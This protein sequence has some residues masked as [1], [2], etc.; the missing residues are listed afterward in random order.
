MFQTHG[1]HKVLFDDN[2]LT[3]HAKGPFNSEQISIYQNKIESELQGRSAPWAQLNILYEDCLYPPEGEKTLHASLKTRKDIGICAIA[4][5]FV[6][7]SYTFI[8]E[9]QLGRMYALHDIPYACF[10]GIEN[11]TIWLREQINKTSKL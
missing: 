4:N 1:E 8:V 2:I 6:E 5:V 9:Q 7:G 11:A 10:D 3:V